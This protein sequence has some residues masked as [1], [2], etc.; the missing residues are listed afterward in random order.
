LEITEKDT[1]V[2]NLKK[3]LCAEEAHRVLGTLRS[4]LANHNMNNKVIVVED[5]IEI[6]LKRGENETEEKASNPVSISGD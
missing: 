1:V 3:P 6:E 2:I 5:G 4:Y